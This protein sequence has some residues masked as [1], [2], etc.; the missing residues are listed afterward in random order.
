[1][2][3]HCEGGWATLKLSATQRD[4]MLSTV[5]MLAEIE[6]RCEEVDP[7]W[8]DGAGAGLRS[9]RR[10]IECLGGSGVVLVDIG[11]NGG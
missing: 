3:W 11:G 8:A 4:R 7:G 10:E 1:M 5:A 2:R 9:A 6:R